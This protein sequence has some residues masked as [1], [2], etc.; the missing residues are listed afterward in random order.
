MK[1]FALISGGT[2]FAIVQPTAYH[3]DTFKELVR[4][5]A[6]AV[7]DELC[8]DSITAIEFDTNL[9]NK[10]IDDS[11]FICNSPLVTY[12]GEG[13]GIMKYHEVY[14]TRQIIYK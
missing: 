4:V 3:L 12:G 8:L 10:F 13:D 2:T 7:K 11:E 6:E 14:F 9:S 5:G 1:A